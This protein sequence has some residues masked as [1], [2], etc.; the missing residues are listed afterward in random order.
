MRVAVVVRS[1]KIGGME[2]VAINLSEA[3]ADAGHESH[4]IYFKDKDR[5]FTPKK[6]VHFHHFDL[7]RSLKLTGIGAILSVFAKLLSGI[8][9]GSFFLYNGLLLAPVF[10]YKL[11]KLEKNYGRFD[12]IIIRGHGT[13][14]LIW[15]IQDDRIV[16]MVESVFIRSNSALDNFYIKCVYSNK[17]LGCV[18]GG[19]KEKVLDVLNTTHVKAKSVELIH[20]PID[21]ELIRK[22]SNEYKPDIDKPYIVSVGRITPNKNISFLL[23]SYKYAKD[24]FSLTMPLI[25]I[26]GGHD[27]ENIKAKIVELDLEDDVK[28]LGMLENPYPWMKNAKL[29]TSTSKAEG[30]GMVLVEALACSTR[31]I[32]TKSIGGVKDIM[33]GDLKSCMVD[34]SKEKFAKKMCEI[35][36]D[37]EVFDFDKYIDKFSSKS[38][39]QRYQEVYL[40]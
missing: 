33:V 7:S 36:D 10:R 40:N 20:N 25:L 35:I 34:F 4:L 14:E 24:N 12:L 32:S 26:G 13:F 19:V 22:K 11:N 6:S 9:R 8:L 21:I 31:V 2:R 17:N 29:L 1:L 39:V 15:P 18:S 37:N 16:Q 3:F 5:V 38:I 28:L 30:F 27:I 23:D